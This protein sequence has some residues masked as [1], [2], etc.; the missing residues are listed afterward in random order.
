MYGLC[1]LLSQI[2]NCPWACVVPS[3]PLGPWIPFSLTYWR[4][5][6][7]DL[8]LSYESPESPSLLEHSFWHDY[9]VMLHILK[10]SKNLN[11]AT[12]HNAHGLPWWEPYLSAPGWSKIPQK[13]CLHAL[14][15]HGVPSQFALSSLGMLVICC[16]SDLY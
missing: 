15:P 1:P 7:S 8:S 4:T 12:L 13:A 2:T 3:S 14:Q 9:A 10:Q 16:S 6:C 5:D 11:R